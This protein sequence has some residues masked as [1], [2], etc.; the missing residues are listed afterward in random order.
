MLAV[1][2]ITANKN[3]SVVTPTLE[4]M[5][6]E[7]VCNELLRHGASPSLGDS[8]RR[9]MGDPTFTWASGWCGGGRRLLLTLLLWEHGVVAR[10]GRDGKEGVMM[11]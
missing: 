9:E 2:D 1:R 7:A 3:H 5:P 4:R 10:C 6:G 8:K 11:K